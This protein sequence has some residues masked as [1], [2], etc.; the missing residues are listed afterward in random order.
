MTYVSEEMKRVG[1]ADRDACV[2]QLAERVATGHLTQADFDRRRD[3]ALAAVTRDQ[4]NELTADLP[5]PPEPAARRYKIQVAGNAYPFSMM[6]WTAGI[7]VSMAMIILPGPL[8]AAASH[9]FGHA[10]GEGAAPIFM[11]LAGVILLFLTG[12]GFAPDGYDRENPRE[13]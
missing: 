5:A 1:H 4:L 3:K 10:P 9:G 13:Y 6:R 7:A 12:I 11:I 8:W 2:D